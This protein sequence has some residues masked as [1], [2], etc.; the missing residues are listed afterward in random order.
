M[1]TRVVVSD[2]NGLHARPAAQFVKAANSFVCDVWIGKDGRM[3]NAKSIVGV[4]SLGVGKGTEIVIKA[5]GQDEEKAVEEL[6]K[7]IGEA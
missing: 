3:V 4:L 5:Q 7:L 2:E 6:K 1:E